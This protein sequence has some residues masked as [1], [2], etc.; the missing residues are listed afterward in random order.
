MKKIIIEITDESVAVDS[1]N[2]KDLT[3]ADIAICVKALISVARM[4]G[5]WA[6]EDT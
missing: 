5:L 1:K 4:L 3:P 2:L 6:R